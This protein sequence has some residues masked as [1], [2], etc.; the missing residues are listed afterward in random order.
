LQAS[1]TVGSFSIAEGRILARFP[2]SSG[3]APY[4]GIG[5]V[6]VTTER[7]VETINVKTTFQG[8]GASAVIGAEIPFRKY[9]FGYVEI[10][11]A[12]VDLKKEVTSG[13]ITGIATVK[14]APVTIGLGL[15]YYL[16]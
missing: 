10:S 16:F 8:S 1:Y 2:L 3:I 4:L 6:N 12:S 11:G 13:G 5:Y 9:L 15:V 14:Y 7:T